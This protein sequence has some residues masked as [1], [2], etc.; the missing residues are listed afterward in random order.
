MKLKKLMQGLLS[1]IRQISQTETVVGEPIVVGQTKL[2]PINRLSMGF[3]FGAGNGDAGLAGQKSGDMGMEMEAVGGG[4]RVHPMA[5]IA[6]DEQGAAQL[7]S[8]DEPEDTVL[9][10]LL[11]VAPELAQRLMQRK[12]NG[13]QEPVGEQKPEQIKS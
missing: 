8:F 2:I 3:G 11:Q 10:K 7:L 4:L 9:D 1:E 6:V 5:F 12:E 13:A